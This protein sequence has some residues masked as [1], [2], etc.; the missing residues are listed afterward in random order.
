MGAVSWSEVEVDGT[1][2]AVPEGASL[3]SAVRAAG[4]ELPALCSDDRLSPAGS[5]RPPARCS[6]PST[7]PRAG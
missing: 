5:C 7:S 3:L 1:G 6:A 4:I 2:V